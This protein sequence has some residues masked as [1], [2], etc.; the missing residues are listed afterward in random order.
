MPISRWANTQTTREA[1]C[2][3]C[4]A[5]PGV[6]CRTPKGRLA[7]TPHGERCLVYIRAI[8]RKEYD[9]RHSGYNGKIWDDDI[10]GAAMSN[11][12]ETR[13]ATLCQ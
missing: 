3:R 12:I 2:P 11:A 1:T 9:R 6:E 8:G 4:M 13:R 5:E 7:G 10:E